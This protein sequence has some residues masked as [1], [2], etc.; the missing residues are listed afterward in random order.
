MSLYSST[1]AVLNPE[2]TSRKE[3]FLK[4]GCL[5]GEASEPV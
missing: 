3:P 5:N 2:Q 1:A 4:E